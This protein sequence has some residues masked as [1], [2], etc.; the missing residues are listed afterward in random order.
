MNPAI[1]NLVISL[2]VMQGPFPPLPSH[3]SQANTPK[4][5]ARKIPFDEPDVL[6]Y[7]R[8]GYVVSQATVLAVFYYVAYK[9]CLSFPF[10]SPFV[11]FG[12]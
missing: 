11:G 12:S 7:V 9:V 8:I 1:Q 6:N 5:V 2:G 4:P 10:P 3:T